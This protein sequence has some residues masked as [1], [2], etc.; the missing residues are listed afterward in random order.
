VGRRK[1]HCCHQRQWRAANPIAAQYARL[2]AK[3]KARGKEFTLTKEDWREFCE[4]T[5]YTESVGCLRME[6]IQCDRIDAR[7]GYHRWNIQALSFGLNREKQQRERGM[8]E[9]PF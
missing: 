7:H 6:D 2:K 8:V 5:G 9:E 3:A 1:C 4:S